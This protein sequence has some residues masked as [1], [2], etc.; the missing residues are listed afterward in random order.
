MNANASW[1]SLNPVT[2]LEVHPS[3]GYSHTS[4]LYKE[5]TENGGNS[6][7]HSSGTGFKELQDAFAFIDFLLELNDLP[8]LD[9][10]MAAWVFE[11]EDCDP[12]LY[13]LRY[14]IRDQI[15]HIKNSGEPE[16]GLLPAH[17]PDNARLVSV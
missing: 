2:I 1:S 15:A 6:V 17:R 5:I 12:G 8:A 7:F 10:E 9:L 16:F 13:Q 3:G 14:Q 11:R 4:T